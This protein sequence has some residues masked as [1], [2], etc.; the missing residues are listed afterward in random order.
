MPVYNAA[1]Y[2]RTA[3]RSILDQDFRDLELLALDDGST[4]GSLEI[5]RAFEA[6]DARVRARTRG[7]RGI[8]ATRNELLQD[9]RAP[10]VAWMDADDISYPSRLRLQMEALD[11]D[12][13]IVCVGGWIRIVDSKGRPIE[14][15]RYPPQHEAIEQAMFE[16]GSAMQLPSVTMRREAALRAGGV[17]DLAPFEDFDLLMRLSELGR[18]ANVQDCILDYRMLPSSASHSTSLSWPALRAFIITMAQDRRTSGADCLQRGEPRPTTLQPQPGNVPNI[19][20]LHQ[21]WAR[22]A[23]A[24]GYLK[25][26]VV[27][28]IHFIRIRLAQRLA[29]GSLEPRSR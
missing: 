1:P 29:L 10:V 12:P 6:S 20:R 16:R 27:H 23:W 3:V 24:N 18:M 28:A 2:L 7:N 21:D 4:D 19:A 26:W 15:R 8:C 22:T 11:Q 17:R 5:L 13:G 9:A 25:T 14:L